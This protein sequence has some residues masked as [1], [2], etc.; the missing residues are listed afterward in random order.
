MR[1]H[2]MRIALLAPPMAVLPLC[3][4]TAVVLAPRGTFLMMGGWR[5][6]GVPYETRGR[7]SRRS[8][9][10][11]IAGMNADTPH[12][13][14][15]MDLGMDEARAKKTMAR[16]PKFLGYNIEKMLNPKVQWLKDLGMDALQVR[17]TIVRH[18]AFLSYSIE[19]NLNPKVQ[20][21][22]EW[23]FAG[24]QLVTMI[25]SL[26]ALLGY[27]SKRLAHRKSVLE[28]RGALSQRLLVNIMTYTDAKFKTRFD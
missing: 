7:L 20:M 18:P 23:D 27:S 16:H 22:R 15:L 6:T 11:D 21:L 17:K 25:C 13:Q 2:P 10:V 14:W 3:L 24:S 12:L 5:S 1:R 8:S 19:K 4:A 28:A 26:P 9:P